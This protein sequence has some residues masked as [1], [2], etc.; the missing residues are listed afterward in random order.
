MT[1]WNAVLYNFEAKYYSDP[2]LEQFSI[3]LNFPNFFFFFYLTRNSKITIWKNRYSYCHLQTKFIYLNLIFL[4]N[5]LLLT[6]KFSKKNFS[7]ISKRNHSRTRY[8]RTAITFSDCDGNNSTRNTKNG[9]W[10]KL[11]SVVTGRPRLQRQEM[12]RPKWWK[13]VYYSVMVCKKKNEPQKMIVGSSALQHD[14]LTGVS[15]VGSTRHLWVGLCGLRG[16]VRVVVS[17]CAS[18]REGMNSYAVS[19]RVHY[20]R[21]ESILWFWNVHRTKQSSSSYFMLGNT[22]N[23][24]TVDCWEGAKFPMESKDMY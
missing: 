12:F 24:C 22:W 13:P 14:V 3:S 23:C 18:K 6:N 2:G 7:A 9:W 11:W 17:C 10:W 15:R 20:G 8:S 21:M 1:I 16:G 19:W 4:K 5:V